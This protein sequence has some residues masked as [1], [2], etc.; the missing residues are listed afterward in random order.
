MIFISLVSSVL[1]FWNVKKTKHALWWSA[2]A[3]L[4]PL[5]PQKAAPSKVV[6]HVIYIYGLLERP[7]NCDLCFSLGCIWAWRRWKSSSSN[8]LRGSFSICTCSW[9]SA[10][11]KRRRWCTRLHPE[12]PSGS[13]FKRK[14]HIFFL[15]WVF[16][17]LSGANHC[18]GFS[19]A[20]VREGPSQGL[21]RK[22][23]PEL[24]AAPG[25]PQ[26]SVSALRG[27]QRHRFA[28]NMHSAAQLKVRGVAALTFAIPASDHTLNLN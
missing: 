9:I 19:E 20:H 4:L 6:D 3:P 11:M 22:V 27:R 25:S 16:F 24:P 1:S 21:H 28:F 15:F 17:F 7:V 2:D 5:K 12:I 14:C 13:V 26:P 8:V 18:L 23:C 10:P